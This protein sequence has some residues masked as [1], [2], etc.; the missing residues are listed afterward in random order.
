[1]LRRTVTA[2]AWLLSVLLLL[3][4]AAVSLLGS[5]TGTR[6]LLARVPALVAGQWQLERSDGTLLGHLHLSGLHWQ[7]DGF[8]LAAG[9]LLLEWQPAALFK[10]ELRIRRLYGSRLRLQLPAAASDRAAPAEAARAPPLLPLALVVD[11]LAFDDLRLTR[12]DRVLNVPAASLVV[13]ADG[14]ALELS[15][16]S[17]RLPAA[18]FSGRGRLGLAEPHPLNADLGWRGRLDQTRMLL[19]RARIEGTLEDLV[20]E[21]DQQSPAPLRARGEVRLGGTDPKLAVSA[22]WAELQWPLS[23]AADGSSRATS[24]KSMIGKMI[25]SAFDTSRSCTIL[26]LRSDAVVSARMIGGWII[27]TSAM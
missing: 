23:G 24:S 2:L 11:Q 22:D 15:H 27:G 13:R 16:L 3:A 1:M 20:F 17:L 9:Q 21:L 7:R 19:G 10:G 18:E 6:W 25:F 5:E 12:G 26:I 14:Q 8:E 4:T